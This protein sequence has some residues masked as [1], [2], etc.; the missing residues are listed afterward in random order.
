MIYQNKPRMQ[1]DGVF[2][3]FDCPDAGQVTARRGRSIT[4]LQALNLLNSRFLMDQSGIL[5][6]RLR[7]EAG[8]QVEA[9]VDRAFAL[10]FNR[11]PDA[12][13]RAAGVVLVKSDGLEAFCR[14]L[15]NTSEWIWV[16]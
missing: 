12:G 13:E 4:P 14:A 8:E 15:F 10:F 16:E 9:E 2:G 1:L 3:A 7:R 6:A 5:A 11:N